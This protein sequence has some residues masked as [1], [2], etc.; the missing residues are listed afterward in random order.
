VTYVISA[1][2]RATELAADPRLHAVRRPV[3]SWTRVTAQ[4]ADAYA[5]ADVPILTD[6]NAPV[7]QLISSLFTSGI[8]R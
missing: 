7:E 2:N 8:G 3:R 4:L 1:S 6:D 5:R